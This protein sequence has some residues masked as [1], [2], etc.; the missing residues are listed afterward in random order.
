MSVTDWAKP[1]KVV[2]MNQEIESPQAREEFQN[3]MKKFDEIQENNIFSHYAEKS[4]SAFERWLFCSGS[5]H[6]IKKRWYEFM[7]SVSA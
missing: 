4:R 7:E 2:T 1:G 5:E 3:V 6:E